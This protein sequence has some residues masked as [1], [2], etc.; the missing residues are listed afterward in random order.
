MTQWLSVR[1]EYCAER[2][3]CRIPS[4]HEE[5]LKASKQEITRISTEYDAVV[6]RESGVLRGACALQITLIALGNGRGVQTRGHQD[7][8]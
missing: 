4:P 3:L 7:P 8:A 1:V 5:K 6:E 2:V